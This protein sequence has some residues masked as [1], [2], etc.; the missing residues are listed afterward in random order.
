MNNIKGVEQDDRALYV[1]V[2]YDPV[3]GKDDYCSRSEHE[4]ALMEMKNLYFDPRYKDC[5][6]EIE[7][8]KAY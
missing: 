7:K 3:W 8:R 1:I 4:E 2:R 5:Y 6:F